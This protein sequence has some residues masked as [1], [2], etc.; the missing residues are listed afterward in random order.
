MTRQ[1]DIVRA[2]KAEKASQEE[3]AANIEKLKHVKQDL[4]TLLQAF[5]EKKGSALNKEKF[6]TEVRAGGWRR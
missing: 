3:V 6:R 2:L 5:K 1:G 4:E